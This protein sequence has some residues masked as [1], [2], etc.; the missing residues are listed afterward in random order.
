MTSS[1]TK[2][3]K[4]VCF[5]FHFV[6]RPDAPFA[7]S[8]APRPRLAGASPKCAKS[9]PYR[10]VLTKPISSSARSLIIQQS[11]LS[12]H[13]GLEPGAQSRGVSTQSLQNTSAIASDSTIEP[14]PTS[15][16]QHD[17][18]PHT[19]QEQ[20]FPSMREMRDDNHGF[21]AIYTIEE[22]RC[23]AHYPSRS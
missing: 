8:K 17:P 16:E 21:Q 5:P 15:H 10:R 9:Y 23:P 14:S 1:T 11:L 18:T 12:L 22:V 4:R 6:T 7:S 3:Q 13:N 19:F 20:A 2:R